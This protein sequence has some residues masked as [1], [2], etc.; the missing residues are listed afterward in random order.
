MALAMSSFPVPLS[1]CT[2]T[3]AS[4]SDT[5]STISNILRISG[6][7]VIMSRR[8]IASSRTRLARHAVLASPD[9]RSEDSI[10][11]LSSSMSKG[12]VM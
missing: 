6:D 11:S 7:T 4:L 3:E 10:V 12:L 5:F 9:S 1:P 2:N 8:W